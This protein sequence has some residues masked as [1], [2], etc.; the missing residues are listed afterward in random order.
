MDGHQKRRK[1]IEARI[2]Q[3]AMQLFRVHGF[4]RVGIEQVAEEAGVSKV[5]LYKYYGNKQTLIRACLLMAVESTADEIRQKLDPEMGL[6]ARL[7]ALMAAKLEL[8]R[9]FSGE[10]MQ[11]LAESD[12][13]FIEQL[14]AIRR[15][16]IMSLSVPILTDARESGRLPDDVPDESFVVFFDLLG[17][18]M[19]M[20]PYYK[21][22]SG[23]N[24]RAFDEIQRIALS[25]IGDV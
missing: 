24:P 1:T 20:S 7:Q 15:E 2:L 8:S 11:E 25:C 19:L 17:I 9:A 13:H 4:R 10:M 14:M 3:A 16:A 6:Q 23:R 18:G 22:Y 5:T 21:E 12:P